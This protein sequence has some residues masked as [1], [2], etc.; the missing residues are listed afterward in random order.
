MSYIWC[1]YFIYN[2]VIRPEECPAIKRFAQR[3]GVEF[4]MM[5]KVDVN[6]ID[7]HAVYHYLKKLAGPVSSIFCNVW[8]SSI[9]YSGYFFILNHYFCNT[10]I[11]QNCWLWYI[12]ASHYMELC[13]VL[14]HYA[15]GCGAVVVGR[16]PCW[17]GTGYPRGNG[18]RWIFG[19]WGEGWRRTLIVSAW[20]FIEWLG[21]K[22]LTS[23][24]NWGLLTRAH[25]RGGRWFRRYTAI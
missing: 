18:R 13:D 15:W 19:W 11:W 9:F 17:L 2:I 6:G 25:L 22:T 14:R 5:N 21:A 3:K 4:T 24:G 1:W 16:R 20:L 23:L 10:I 7:A 12:K 8:L